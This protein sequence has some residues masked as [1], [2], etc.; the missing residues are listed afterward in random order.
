M[1]SLQ[2][3]I[4]AGMIGLGLLVSLVWAGFLSLEAFKLVASLI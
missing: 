1:E 3:A 2:S 4:L